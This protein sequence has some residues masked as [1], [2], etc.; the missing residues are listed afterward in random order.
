M[1]LWLYLSPTENSH[2]WVIWG[3]TPHMCLP[4]PTPTPVAARE[5]SLWSQWRAEAIQGHMLVQQTAETDKIWQFKGVMRSYNTIF[6]QLMKEYHMIH[7][8]NAFIEIFKHIQHLWYLWQESSC[9]NSNGLL[10]AVE[11]SESPLLR[12]SSIPF[13][14]VTLISSSK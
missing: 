2:L 3:G 13:W 11:G 9:Y 10:G 7:K 1:I 12:W 4:P 6:L 8:V 14:P 5:R